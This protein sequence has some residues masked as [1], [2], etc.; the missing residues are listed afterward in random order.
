MNYFSF[1]LSDFVFV[2]W[3]LLFEALPF[4]ALGALISGIVEQCLSRATVARLFPR[5]RSVGILASAGLGLLLPMCECGVVPIVRRLLRK[6]VPV[7]CGIAY[8]LASPIVN[9]LVILSTYVAFRGREGWLMVGLRVGLGYLIA[10][11][12]A[13]LVWKL[14]GEKGLLRDEVAAENGE[15]DRAQSAA[16]AER[17]HGHMH[18]HVHEHVHEYE[19]EPRAGGFSLVARIL[20]VAASDFIVIGGT[21]AVGAAVAALINSGFSRASLAVW[22]ENPW[23]AVP[24]MMALAIA[25][26]LCSEADAFVAAS[27]YAFPLAAKVAFLV[28]GPMVDIKLA[29]VYCTVFRPRAV[30]AILGLATLLVLV[31]CLTMPWWLPW[32]DVAAWW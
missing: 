12:V 20:G 14:L 27:F 29:L 4:V 26:N 9:P 32:L 7:S 13:V 2:W 11:T 5:R 31:S 25:L 16:S 21:L 15:S 30:V 24:G 22:A 28:L 8:L 10:V 3:G 19:N 18:E 23:L 1:N 17:D 6:G